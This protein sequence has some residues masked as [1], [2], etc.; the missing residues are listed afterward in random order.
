ML[1]SR[2]YRD[3]I[4][5]YIQMFRATVVL[6]LKIHLFI[7]ASPSVNSDAKFDKPFTMQKGDSMPV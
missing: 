4:H 7:K 3:N 6:F 5:S 2:L 1:L